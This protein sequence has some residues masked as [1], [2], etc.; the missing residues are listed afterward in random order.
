MEN[1]L[2][3]KGDTSLFKKGIF[4]NLFKKQREVGF[5][6]VLLI[7][8]WQQQVH[9]GQAEPRNGEYPRIPGTQV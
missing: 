8:Q 5:L 7:P 1:S 6:H 2:G 3:L 9:L 4:K